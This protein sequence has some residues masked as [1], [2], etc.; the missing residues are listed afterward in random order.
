MKYS[1]FVWLFV[2]LLI[3]TLVPATAYAETYQLDDADMSIV[4][5]DTVWYVFTR[6]NIEDNAELEELGLSYDS[7]HSILHDNQAYM[8]AILFFED[9]EYVELFLRKKLLDVDVGNLS[10]YSDEEVL[11]FAKAY[12]ERQNAQE[13]SVYKNRYKFAK[14]EYTDT[15]EYEGSQTAYN[16]CEFLTIVNNENYTLTFQSTSQL[17]DSQYEEIIRI[18]DSVRFDV[19]TSTKDGSETSANNRDAVSAEEKVRTSFWNNVIT[20]AIGGAMVGG[21]LGA[22]G[23]ILGK[24]R[25]SSRK[26]E[27]VP[28][29]DARKL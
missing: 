12:A 16:I 8:D 19:D 5:D 28:M 11:E 9:G 21:M 2:V 14:A 3:L 17:S 7:M 13:Y 29:G 23:G 18:V 6:E 26:D 25:K 1:R 15:V 22:I 20:K 27:T 10:N 24:K 4:V